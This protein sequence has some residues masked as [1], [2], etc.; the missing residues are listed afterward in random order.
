MTYWTECQV[1]SGISSI[2]ASSA[3]KGHVCQCRRFF[4]PTTG[5][6]RP[7]RPGFRERLTSR[8]CATSVTGPQLPPEHGQHPPDP[9]ANWRH[10]GSQRRCSGCDPS[11][12]GILTEAHPAPGRRGR[13]VFSGFQQG[14]ERVSLHPVI[15][16]TWCGFYSHP[17]GEGSM[18][19]IST[20][21]YCSGDG[22]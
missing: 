1:I 10:P 14:Y 7:G 8:Y 21:S 20:S 13:S 4:I 18:K 2:R 5:R 12:D 19:N 11:E 16:R 3:K 15:Q 6:V 9:K 17:T 22:P